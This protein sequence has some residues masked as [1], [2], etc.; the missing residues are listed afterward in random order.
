MHLGIVVNYFVQLKR[1]ICEHLCYFLDA[2]RDRLMKRGYFAIVW[3]SIMN[4][5]SKFICYRW[6]YLSLL[7]FNTLDSFRKTKRITIF[8]KLL[9][10]FSR[11]G[12]KVKEQIRPLQLLSC[13]KYLKILFELFSP[14]CMVSFVLLAD[15]RQLR[16]LYWFI[17]TALRG[18]NLKMEA[19]SHSKSSW[20]RLTGFLAALVL[21]KYQ[22]SVLLPMEKK[23]PSVCL[24]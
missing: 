12:Q 16:N 13:C 17:L 7:V 1:Y 20:R 10:F 19:E 18:N 21:I 14:F 22:I 6:F 8:L 24:T 5:V 2:V 4:I 11:N 15:R 3:L 9:Y 23:S